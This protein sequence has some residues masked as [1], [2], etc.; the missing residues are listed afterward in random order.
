MS[1]KLS[2]TAVLK[3]FIADL[4]HLDGTHGS[5]ERIGARAAIP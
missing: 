5:D 4:C 1:G 2:A 3:G